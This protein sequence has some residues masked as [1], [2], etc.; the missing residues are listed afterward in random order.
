MTYY[1]VL[2]LLFICVGLYAIINPAGI[3]LQETEQ[4]YSVIDL[5]RGWGIYSVTIGAILGF[6]EKIKLI[7]LLCFSSSIIW[8]V[9]IANKNKWTLHHKHSI[10]ANAVAFII[11]CKILHF[12]SETDQLPSVLKING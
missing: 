4:S 5:I 1:K 3:S 6:P 9:L 2:Q 8:H 7:L 10:F 12:N 11:T